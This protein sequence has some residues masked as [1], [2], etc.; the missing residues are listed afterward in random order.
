MVGGQQQLEKYHSCARR[1]DAGSLAGYCKRDSEKQVGS[2]YILEKESSGLA[3]RL[4][5]RAR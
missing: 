5:G 2:G 4:E 3:N 1:E